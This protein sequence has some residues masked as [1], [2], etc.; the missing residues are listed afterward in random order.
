M[1]FAPH[2]GSRTQ[3]GF[4]VGGVIVVADRAVVVVY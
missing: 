2:E 4:F 3:G 1:A